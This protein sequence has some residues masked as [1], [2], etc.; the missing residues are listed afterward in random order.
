MFEK[1]RDSVS[2]DPNI[3]VQNRETYSAGNAYYAGEF[4]DT[5]FCGLRR[6]YVETKVGGPVTHTNVEEAEQLP[7]VKLRTLNDAYMGEHLVYYRTKLLDY[8]HITCEQKIYSIFY[9]LRETLA[10]TDQYHQIN[11]KPLEKEF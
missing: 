5:D 9:L 10:I 3:D 2:Q 8:P 6:Y 7:V 4:T 1:T 11:G